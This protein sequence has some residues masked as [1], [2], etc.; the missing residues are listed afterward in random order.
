[1]AELKKQVGIDRKHIKKTVAIFKSKNRK[2]N[3]PKSITL[4]NRMSGNLAADILLIAVLI[5][6]F[7]ILMLGV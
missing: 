7:K 4:Y 3:N 5:H 2:R 1:M 6:S